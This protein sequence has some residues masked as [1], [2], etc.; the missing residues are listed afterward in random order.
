MIIGAAAVSTLT[1]CPR[2]ATKYGGP[3]PPEVE[4]RDASEPPAVE[5]DG[6]GEVP[7]ESTDAGR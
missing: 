5:A 7:T 1:G 3:P 4:Q 6:D 2:P